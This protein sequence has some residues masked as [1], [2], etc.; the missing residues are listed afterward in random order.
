M[1]C[2]S[3]PVVVAFKISEDFK[4]KGLDADIDDANPSPEITIS[5][6]DKISLELFFCIVL[7]ISK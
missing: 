1:M 3:L 2:I 4:I 5:P 6:V 7:F